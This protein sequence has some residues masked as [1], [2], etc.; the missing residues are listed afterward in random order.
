[1]YG[2]HA[3][4]AAQRQRRPKKRGTR[5][6]DHGELVP[7]TRQRPADGVRRGVEMTL[8]VA[9]ADHR[10]RV[11]AHRAIVGR[12]E[13]PPELRLL[14]Q[15]R[16]VL[17]GHELHVAARADRLPFRLQLHAGHAR[18]REELARPP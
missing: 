2:I 15:R 8:P 17:P 11:R 4:E 3:P 5:D 12:L 13:E 1:M 7:L 6:A 9:V 10:H 14:P 18:R 16:E